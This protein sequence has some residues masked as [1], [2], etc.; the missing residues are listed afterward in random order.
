LAAFW[1]VKAED[2]KVMLRLGAAVQPNVD[3]L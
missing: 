1:G 3:P 2:A